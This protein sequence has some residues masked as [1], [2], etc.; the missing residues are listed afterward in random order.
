MEW[1]ISTFGFTQD[2]NSS[3]LGWSAASLTHPPPQTPSPSAAFLLRN[4][5]SFY[6]AFL[7]ALITEKL[8][9]K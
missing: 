9:R 6:I 4:T 1:S 8:V 5:V 7:M 2:V 3:L